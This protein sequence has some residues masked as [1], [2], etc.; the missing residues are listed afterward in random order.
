MR[1]EAKPLGGDNPDNVRRAIN[2]V[3]TKLKAAKKIY[4]KSP[5]VWVI[6]R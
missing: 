6:E 3:L 2:R 1:T 4:E 5:D